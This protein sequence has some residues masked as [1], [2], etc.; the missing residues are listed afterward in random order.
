VATP[1]ASAQPKLRLVPDAPRPDQ[2]QGWGDWALSNAEAGGKLLARTAERRWLAPL[3]LMTGGVNAAAHAWDRS[4]FGS[5]APTLVDNNGAVIGG[6]PN[7]SLPSPSQALINSTGVQMDPNAGTAMKV[8]DY[9]LPFLA[10]G[11]RGA[12]GRVNEATGA[13]NKTA[14][15]LGYVAGAGTDAALSYLGGMA[16]DKLIGGPEGAFVGS[17]FGGG[18][19]PAVQRGFGWMQQGTADPNAGAIFDAMTNPAGPNAMPTYGQLSGPTGKQFEKA[20]EA[21]PILRSG[22]R[23]QR[24]NA[25]EGIT[26]AVAT[27]I[28]EVGDRAPTTSPVSPDVTASRIINLSRE[29]NQSQQEQLS[30]QQQA[31]EDAIG[32]DRPTNVSDLADTLSTLANNGPAPITRVIRPRVGDLYQSVSP[33]DNYAAMHPDEPYAPELTAPYGHLKVLRTDLGEKTATTDPVKGPPYNEAYGAYTDA[34]RGGAEE[35]GQGPQFDQANLDYSTFK[36][37]NQ[38]WLERQGGKLD[39]DVQPSPAT[40]ASRANAI[41]GSNPG[42][43]DDINTQ[44]G[45]GPARN[46][47]ADV[48]SNLGRIKDQSTPSRWGSDYAGVNDRTKQFIADNAPTA[49]PYLENAAI[50]GRA[51]DLQPERPGMSNSIGFLGG[52]AAMLANH[53][54]VAALTAGALET[55]SV[56]RA[57]AG[58][59]DIPSLL[60]QYANRQGVAAGLRG[61]Q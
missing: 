35:A 5:P 27:G 61:P 38:P 59:T 20:V 3:D 25:E 32:T 21:V 15:G 49:T 6:G 39:S 12:V 58:R 40:I 1:D 45:L 11:A 26:N 9:V 36:Q 37:V 4:G 41:P 53:P 13:V 23:A 33:G 34:M 29:A 56:L 22:V 10:S 7:A 16:G 8:A 50:G 14:E 54:K 44:L 55:P 24:A 60:A 28:G 30:A 18:A 2:S 48:L 47:L 19:R 57:R 43:L 42:Y 31:L 52:L 51:F 17:L 46:T